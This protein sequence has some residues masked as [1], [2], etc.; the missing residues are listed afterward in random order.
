MQ[1]DT[2]NESTKNMIINEAFDRIRLMLDRYAKAQQEMNYVSRLLHSWIAVYEDE[3]G[4]QFP[5]EMLQQAGIGVAR[6]VRPAPASIVIPRV[7]SIPEAVFEM[8]RST[9]E[10]LHL[11]TIFER[12]F[13]KG[14]NPNVKKPKERVR[15]ALLRGMKRGIY[16]RT[17]PNTFKINPSVR[18]KQYQELLE[19]E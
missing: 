10:P 11:N 9:S 6:P 4:K 18:N 13:S 19:K 7:L 17:A 8:M 12:V 3:S 5:E 14:Y 2:T 15:T 16:E 1:K